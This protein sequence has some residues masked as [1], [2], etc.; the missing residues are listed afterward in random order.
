ML[1][2]KRLYSEPSLFEPIDFFNGF[3]LILGETTD[4]SVKTNGVGKSLCIEFINYALLKD[5]GKSRVS[6]IP[7]NDLPEGFEI[8]LDFEIDDKKITIRRNVFKEDFPQ[9]YVNG[10]LKPVANKSQVLE[11]L[12]SLTFGSISTNESPSFR[13]IL[14]PLIRDE[15]SEFKSIIKCFDT[16][17]RIPPD[18]E[19]HLYLLGI[20]PAPYNQANHLSRDLEKIRAAKS[21]VKESVEALTGKNISE[22]KADLN[23]LKNQAEKTQKDIDRLENIEGYDIV[24][25]EIIA[26]ED[27]IEDKRARQEVLKSEISKIQL[28]KG[29]NYIDENEVADLY[30]QFKDGLGDLIKKELSEVSAFK[31]KIDDF[32]RSLI[33]ERKENVA[34]EI[35]ALDEEL[36]T[37]DNRYK[38]KVSLLDQ[39]GLLKSLKKTIAIHQRKMEDYSSL[40]SFLEAFSNHEQER[41]DK[42]IERKN[43]IHLLDT[44]VI[45]AK[46]S[47]E[48]IES[49]I[50]EMH[51]YVYG[52]QQCSFDV[53][54]KD[55]KEIV[56]FDLRIYDDGSHSIDR[57]KVFFYDYALLTSP[58]TEGRHPGLLIHDNIFEVDRDT[59]IKNLDYISSTLGSLANKQYILTLNK[60]M[61]SPE[62]LRILKLNMSNHVRTTF[63]KNKRFLNIHYQELS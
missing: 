13:S 30:N 5:H 62:D 25:S 59:L 34:K 51:E 37:L 19:P 22:A 28:F 61:L 29:D 17:K 4:N 7:K 53:E 9:L 56:K 14:G 26:L 10:K 42:D 52:N 15:K 38:E 21:K 48:S 6:K 60:D 27:E 44:Y 2:I 18:Y 35:G 16:D 63:T 8:C 11:Y 46:D 3:N 20:N 55:N 54:V 1:T 57:E 23:D 24:K 36:K 50:L 41:K 47:V 58:S 32:Q 12:T 39:E 43:Q 40:N 45:E 33:N 49:L 31:K